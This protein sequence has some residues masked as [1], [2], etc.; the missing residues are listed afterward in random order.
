M[1]P[2]RHN[3]RRCLVIPDV[4]Q[5]LRWLERVLAAERDR[6]DLVVFLGDYFDS[7]GKDAA[8]AGEVARFIRRVRDAAPDQVVLLL[9]NHDL[10]YLEAAPS[11]WK[12]RSPKDLRHQ[13][14]GF[15][16]NKARRIAG[17]WDA[18]FWENLRL[19]AVV[20]GW[21]LSHAGVASVFAHADLGAEAGLDAL[22][23]DCRAALRDFR[24]QDVP[25]LGAGV[26]RGGEQPVGGLLWQDWHD[27][28][29]DGHPLP[30]IVGHTR[31]RDGASGARTKGRSWCLDGARTCYGIL[32]PDG[33][34]VRT[35]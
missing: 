1:K 24:R 27:E 33:L 11:C 15:S 31:P 9:G 8:P 10:H 7:E 18:G 5:D 12:R 2:Y 14:T 35:A 30:Q 21:L 17:E 29:E 22:D 16:K 4:H 23:E 32:T 26:V 3:V 13:C 6:S 28:F 19:F 34:D 25:L 20:N